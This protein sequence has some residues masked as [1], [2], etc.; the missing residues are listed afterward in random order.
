MRGLL[1]ESFTA[2]IGGLILFW[3]LV[4]QTATTGA[5]PNAALVGAGVTLL[6]GAPIAGAVKIVQRRDGKDLDDG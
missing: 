6:L 1:P 5:E 2:L 3:Q 4:L